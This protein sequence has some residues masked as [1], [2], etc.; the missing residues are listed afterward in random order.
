MFILKKLHGCLLS[1]SVGEI[2]VRFR[3]GFISRQTGDKKKKPK[4]ENGKSRNSKKWWKSNVESLKY[5]FPM[6]FVKVGPC[7]FW[8]RASSYACLLG[9]DLGV[10][11]GVGRDITNKKRE[12]DE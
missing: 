12:S 2:V 8:F 6:W 7:S 4:T 11:L 5:R 9:V 3:G 10:N 1:E